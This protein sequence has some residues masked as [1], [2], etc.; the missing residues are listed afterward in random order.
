LVLGLVTLAGAGSPAAQNQSPSDEF[1]R[2][3]K[4][5]ERYRVLAAQDDGAVLPPTKKPVEPGGHYSGVPRLT[6]LLQLVGDLPAETRPA[7]S[8]LYTGALVTAVKRFQARHGLEPDGRIGQGT[9]AQLNTPLAFR[10]RQLELALERWRRLPYDPSRRAI[11]LNLPEFRLRAVDP[12]RHLDLDMKIVI[13]RA[14]KLK[15]PLLSSVI[16]TVIFRPYWNVPHSIQ[17]HELVA[18]IKRD[19]SYISKNNFELVTP[20]DT[21][22]AENTVSDKLL[23]QL[24]SGTLRLRQRPG[25]KNS[26]G[27]VKFVFPNEYNVYMHDTPAKSLFAR[28]RRDFSHGCIRLE[29]AADLAEWVLRVESGWPRDRIDAAMQGTESFSVKLKHPIPVVTIYVTA[30]ALEN[31][32]VHFFEDIYGEDAA[33]EEEMA[34]AAADA[35]ITSGEPGRHPRE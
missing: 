21:V 28:A 33:L 32:E 7:D 16:D 13:G 29:R 8:D 30:V 4:A 17:R 10:V 15:T 20:Q 25:P 19:P 9:L 31:G 14:S 1:Q 5:L 18:D 6:R 27:L 3:L 2:T 24:R 22:V 26:L 11:L 34:G 12:G 35:G 23:A